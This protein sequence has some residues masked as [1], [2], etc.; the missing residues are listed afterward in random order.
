MGFAAMIR[1]S[2]QTDYGIQLLVQFAGGPGGLAL[3]ARELA[4]RARLPLPMVSKVLKALAREGLLVSQRGARGG[5]VL[6]RKPNEVRVADVIAALDGDV[7]MTEC[8]HASG[9]CRR[10]PLCPVRSNWGTINQTVRRALQSITLWDMTQ[11]LPGC[12][13]PLRTS[14]RPVA[15]YGGRPSSA[16]RGVSQE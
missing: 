1:M 13:V 14:S 10:A 5:Y 3:S 2:K 15:G 4:Q 12:P 16:D 11:P 8:G 6:S 7:A 9:G